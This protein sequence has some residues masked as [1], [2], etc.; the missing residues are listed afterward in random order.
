MAGEAPSRGETGSPHEPARFRRAM[1]RFVSGV[2]VVTVREGEPERIHGATVSAFMSVSEA[3]PLAAVCLSNRSRLSGLLEPGR[4]CGVSLLAAGQDLEAWRFA[5]RPPDGLAP[6]AF[7]SL[8]GAPVLRGSIAQLAA[9]VA[10]RHRAGDHMLI[11]LAVEQL[12]VDR[13]DAAP[14][15]YFASAF[16]RLAAGPTAA[17]PLFEP[18]WHG[19]FGE[20]WG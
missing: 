20:S 18:G 4:A 5:G 12:A 1:G 7:E 17:A 16:H 15:V 6:P 10:A 8:G 13:R 14:L 19:A 9:V 3:P 11:V 2:T